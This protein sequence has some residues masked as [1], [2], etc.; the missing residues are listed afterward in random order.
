LLIPLT[1]VGLFVADKFT[2]ITGT[3][4]LFHLFAPYGISL[5][6]IPDQ[7][8]KT[9]LI[10]GANSGLGF[11]S[12]SILFSKNAEVIMAFRTRKKAE[13]A[14]DKIMKKYPH[15]KGSLI[16]MD[17]DNTSLKSVKKF[18]RE[19]LALNRPI[20]GLILNAGI[21]FPEYELTEDGIESQFGVNHV[22]HFA[23]TKDLLPLLEK[24]QSATIV[25]VSSLGH[26]FTVPEGVKMSINEINDKSKYN[27][28][29]WYGQSKLANLLFARELARR[30]KPS[31]KVNACHPGG[32]NG[33]LMRH[34]TKGSETLDKIVQ[35]IQSLIYWSEEQGSLTVL[36][37][38][39]LP[40]GTGGY[41]VPLGRPDEGSSQSR[42]RKLA[43][44]L[45]EFTEQILKEKG[46]DQM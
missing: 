35:I 45:W 22:A 8:G 25:S 19:V 46:Y 17:L 39:V 32:V 43:E 9:Y 18:A 3:L 38:A 13:E 10:T 23:L 15:S 21:I 27:K 29:A 34:L 1:L 33:N 20:N 44:R 5:N 36:K 30:V 26:W 37:P 24:S 7:A 4:P 6:D 12:A 14:R 42:D 11:G 2:R 28:G 16:L 31:I 40:N 41:Y